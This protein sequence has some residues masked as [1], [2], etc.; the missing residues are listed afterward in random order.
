MDD[1]AA[2][3]QV[4][5]FAKHVI[6]EEKTT[7]IQ[8]IHS[9]TQEAKTTAIQDIHSATQEAKT[10]A[11]RKIESTTQEATTS[12]IRDIHSTT[13]E[14]MKTIKNATKSNENMANQSGIYHYY[15]NIPVNT[16]FA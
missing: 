9:S 2:I 4:V 13:Q 16:I 15:F 10:S 3:R 12:A 11:I 1:E 7:A 5:K 6:Q 8:D 14:N